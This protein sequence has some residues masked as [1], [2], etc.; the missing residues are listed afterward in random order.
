[1]VLQFDISK[2]MHLEMMDIQPTQHQCRRSKR[3]WECLI[4]SK[5]L[6]LDR[7]CFITC[8]CHL[9]CCSNSCYGYVCSDVAI[10]VSNH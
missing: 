3:L 9:I 7:G 6:D 8:P 10:I 1:M 5:H 2:D 4:T